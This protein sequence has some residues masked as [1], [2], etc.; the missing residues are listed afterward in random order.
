[1]LHITGKVVVLDSGFYVIQGFGG[2]TKKG[3]YG[4]SIIKKRRY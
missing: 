3:V 1:M 2:K 4:S